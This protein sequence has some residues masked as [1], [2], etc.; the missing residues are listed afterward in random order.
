MNVKNIPN[1]MKE[2]TRRSIWKKGETATHDAGIRR[3][4]L[5]RGRNPP[6]DYT[7]IHNLVGTRIHILQG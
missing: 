3:D 6:V 4:H 2:I 5:S 1:K 7:A